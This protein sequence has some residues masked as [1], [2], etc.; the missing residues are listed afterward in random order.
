[1]E[2]KD[3]FIVGI[4]YSAGGLSVLLN[5]L[6]CLPDEP[7]AAFVIIPHLLPTY[8]SRLDEIL[9]QCCQM[10]VNRV[11]G[12]TDIKINQVY[13]I[14]ENTELRISGNQLH[15]SSR[16][17]RMENKAIDEF[18]LSLADTRKTRAIAIILSGMGND[19]AKG[20]RHIHE[21]GGYVLVQDP[22]TALYDSMPKSIIRA[23]SPLLISS[24]SQMATFLHTLIGQS[25]Q[26]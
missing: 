15:V 3:F 21:M 26:V 20:A 18:F 23:D 2:D 9:K 8:R 11:N 12:I 22:D 19:G 14:E 13:L 25:Q 7:G 6:Q 24:P 10:P 5:F 16:P 17:N 4:G 1:M